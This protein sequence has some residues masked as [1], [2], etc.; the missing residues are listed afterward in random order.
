MRLLGCL[1]SGPRES[2]GCSIHPLV[3]GQRHRVYF[4][5]PRLF[6]PWSALHRMWMS[7]LGPEVPSVSPSKLQTSLDA[8]PCP[9]NPT[10]C[11]NLRNQ[12]SPSASAST[13]AV[14]GSSIKA[15]ERPHQLISTALQS[16]EMFATSLTCDPSARLSSLT[17][18]PGPWQQSTRWAPL[19]PGQL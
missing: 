4:P 13:M 10:T 2:Q 15:T 1:P 14:C 12:G 8:V 11:L 9:T 17:S 3:I 16:L 18:K 7:K 5:H 19:V 6:F